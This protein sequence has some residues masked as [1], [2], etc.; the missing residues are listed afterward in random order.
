M[1]QAARLHPGDNAERFSD[2]V[3]ATGAYSFARITA[4]VK[5]KVEDLR[6]RSA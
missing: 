6:P 2:R 1:V 3:I 4:A 5:M